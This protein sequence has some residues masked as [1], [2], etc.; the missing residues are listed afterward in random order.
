MRPGRRPGKGNHPQATANR[1]A[2]GPCLSGADYPQA[3]AITP[4]V[5]SFGVAPPCDT[6]RVVPA[7]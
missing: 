7:R 1:V 5:S 2:V 6:Y 4:V 3:A